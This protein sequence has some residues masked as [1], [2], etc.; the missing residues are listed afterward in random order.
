[1]SLSP[2]EF[3]ILETMF[4]RSKPVGAAQIAIENSK[5]IS[6]TMTH[7]TELAHRGYIESPQK[8]LYTLTTEGKKIL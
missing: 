5:E 2:V 6:S 1:M 3:E 7:L 8:E 4:L